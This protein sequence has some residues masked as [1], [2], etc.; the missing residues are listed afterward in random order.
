MLRVFGRNNLLLMFSLFVWALG[1]GMWINLR[2]LYLADLGASAG[3]VGTALAVESLAR[4]ALLIPAGYLTDRFGA[5][6]IVILSWVMGLAGP[7]LMIPAR[8]WPAAVPGMA[9]YAA[10]A[11]AI[12]SVSAMALLSLPDPDQPGISQR[13]L[14]AIFAAYPAGLIV[15]PTLGGLLADRLGIRACLW[16]GA[17]LF[18][19][20]LA[21]LLL[22][23]DIAP[24][25]R[26]PHQRR[27]DLLRSRQFVTR[28]LYYGFASFSFLLALAL[29]PNYL[30]EVRGFTLGSIGLLFSLMS[31]GTVLINLAVGRL[32]PRWNYPLVLG[33]AWLAVLG[34]WQAQG[35]PL[36]GLAFTG[37]GAVWTARTL[38]TAGIAGVVPPHD[39]GLAFGT[40]DTLI[41]LAI[42][43]AARAAGVLY[44]RT[45]SH[46]LPFIAALAGL[47][48]LGGLWPIVQPPAA[49]EIR[50]APA[51]TPSAGE[52]ETT[53]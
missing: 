12:P 51:P 29:A 41:A 7:L 24:A 49:A 10:S 38:G 48:A 37:L 40:A 5:R 26:P 23:R 33:I 42:A 43:A 11:F 32:P 2:Q 21:V 35:L 16:I 15:S 9:V 53:H 27:G 19:I 1:E 13:V 22:T 18:T 20:S 4:A 14:T 36:A 25:G 31:L 34:I 47:I 30:Q 44:E 28:A 45:P 46:D 8:T 50:P 52:G 6:L 3:Q 39:R 17:V